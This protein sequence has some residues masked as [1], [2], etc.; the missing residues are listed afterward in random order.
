MKK[1]AAF[2]CLSLLAAQ[3]QTNL[4]YEDFEDPTV[5]YV[6][7]I[8]ELSDGEG[9]Y[10]G[11]VASD[12]IS[13]GSYV[14]YTNLH[15]NGYFGGQDM[16]ADPGAPG[17]EATLSWNGLDIFGMTGLVF[18]ALF[19]EDVG[20]NGDDDWDAADFAHVEYRIDGGGWNNLLWFE[21][22]G[23]QYNS[24]AYEDTDF[25]GIGDDAALTDAFTLFEKSIPG[26]GAALDLR[27]SLHLD[28]GDEDI[29]FD[30]VTLSGYG[31]GAVFV[32]NP[33]DVSAE[34]GGA[35]QVNVYWSPNA[36]ADDVL[37]ARSTNNVFGIPAKG[38][39]FSYVDTVPGG[40]EVIFNGSGFVVM[41][42]GLEEDGE[43]YFRIWSVDSE[44]NYSSGVTVNGLASE[45][46]EGIHVIHVNDVH[47]RLTTHDYDITGTNDVPVLEKVGGAAYMAAKMLEL[48]TAEPGSVI[49]DAGD[50]S[51][52][53]VLGDIDGNRGLIQFYNELDRKLKLQRGRGLDAS[54]VGNH[55][56]RHIDM[57][58]NM[59]NLANFPFISMNIVHEGTTT[60]YFDPYV[61][62]VADGKKVG[63]LGYTTDTSSHLEETTEPVIDV[64][65]CSWNNNASDI[66]IKGY[67]DHLRNVEQCDMVLLLVHVGHSRVASDSDGKWQLV[68][69]D[70]QTEPPDVVVGGHWHTMTETVWQPSDINHKTIIAEAASYCQY[71][72]EIEL[73]DDGSYI[74][75][76][77]NVVRCADITPDP[78]VAQVVEDLKTEYALNPHTKYGDTNVAYALDQVIGYS[79]VDLRLNKDK[80]FTHS[81][82]PWAGDNA[83]GAWVSDS[84]QWYID[85]QTPDSCDLALQSGGGV[86]RDNAAGEITYLELYETYPWQDDNMVLIEATGQEIWDFIEEDHCG[87][88]I[89]RGWQVFADDGVIYK[90]EKGGVPINPTD[91]FNVAVSKYMYAHD[92]DFATGG[93][94]DPTPVEYDYSIRQTMIDYTSQF[95]SNNPMQVASDRY[96]LNTGSAGRFRAVVTMVDDANSEPYFESAYVRLLSATDDTVARRGG[97]V[98]A[99]L[100]NADGSINAT[101]RLA[102]VMLYRSYLGFEEG[103]LTNGMLIDIEGEFGFHAGNPQF[104]DQK[105]IVA[106]GVEFRIVGTNTALALP[107]FKGSISEFWDE[108]HENRYVAFEGEK[109][110]SHKITDRMGQTLSVYTEGGYD[111]MALPGDIGDH[112]ELA[113]VQTMRYD[114]RRFRCAEAYVVESAPVDIDYLPF[115]L[116]D[117]I[118]PVQQG[119]SPLILAASASDSTEESLS[120]LLPTDDAHVESGDQ[121]RNSGSSPNLYLQSSASSPYGNERI[122]TRFDLSGIPAGA[123]IGSAAL[124]LYCYGTYNATSEMDVDVHGATDDSWS[125]DSITWSNQPLFGA[126]LDMATLSTESYKWY[127]WDVTSFVESERSGDAAVS[128]VVKAAVEDAATANNLVF[129]AKEYNGGAKG[130]FLK[131]DYAEPVV[132]GG[133]VASVDFYYRHSIDGSAWTEW[134]IAGTAS[135]AP[136]NLSFVYPEGDGWYEF[137]SVAT[138]NTGNEEPMP[139]FADARVLFTFDPSAI[140]FAEALDNHLDWTTGGS[141]NWF[142]QTVDTGDGVDAARSGSI[143]DK[144]TSWLE[145][146]VA[147][148]GTLTFQWKVSSEDRFDGLAFMVDG[149]DELVLNG[150]VD[151][152]EASYQIED[153]ASHVLRWEYYKDSTLST[154]EDCGWLDQVLWMPHYEGFALW[155]NEMGYAGDLAAFLAMDNNSNGVPNAFEYAFGTNAQNGLMLGIRLVDGKPVVETPAQDVATLPYVDVAVLGSTNLIDWTLTVLPTNGAPDGCAWF[156]TETQPTNAFF[157]LEAGLVE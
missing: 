128:L 75:S 131:I 138:D 113:G 63:I 73:A 39:A 111:L 86:R 127:G 60:P 28:S 32:E 148:P 92:N 125:E 1:I 91:T 79:A 95:T 56:V 16:D 147:G 3:A 33:Q 35:G 123:V 103:A 71:V 130:P 141:S 47:S 78:D 105:G 26:T 12:G 50:V 157:K 100:V 116:V 18:S 121:G 89:S 65:T 88:S 96:V 102:E 77:K 80:W 67:V 108:Y 66:Q 45:Y 62:V 83:A 40:G 122:W 94:G 144:E 24:K 154:G 152:T 104:V 118:V 99:N 31:T 49:V 14:V 146:S 46:N 64:L 54:V 57:L 134:T 119:D 25:D 10:F 82:F 153:N 19:A 120:I 112:L 143:A 8:A 58:N 22:D 55:D 124:E 70:G 43:Y 6:P 38:T 110:G 97:Y 85:T 13:V 101:N 126:S 21:N 155:A 20:Y 36:N 68:E 137:F 114:E 84:M 129:D 59:K 145:T 30:N 87:T 11:R 133:S 76:W 44:T 90:I 117:A 151:W 27:I 156:R 74:D 29:A 81:E 7:S 139:R 98:D 9:D 93:W 17:G 149:N 2:F 69:D 41:N 109:T 51:E 142:V 52:G 115:S 37:I 15:G 61:T 34:P 5:G 132:T 23:A 150:E 107:D 135:V 72:G 42:A 48:A 53:N 136:W 140:G 106:D 4:L